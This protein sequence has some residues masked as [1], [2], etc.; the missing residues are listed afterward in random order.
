MKTTLTIAF[1]VIFHSVALAGAK[2]TFVRIE[3]LAEQEISEKILAHIYQKIG[4]DIN[5]IQLPGKR[6]HISVFSENT[7]GETARIFSYGEKN[8]TLIRVP[9]SYNSLETT[10]FAL[11]G[12]KISVTKKEDLNKYR[13]VV[14]RGVQ[15]TKDITKGLQGVVELD[16]ICAMMQFIKLGRADIALTNT[17]SGIGALKRLKTDDIVAVGT[18][19]ELNLYHYLIPKHGDIVPKVDAAIRDM[20]ASG[21]LRELRERFE[22]QY[23][24]NIQ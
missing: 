5:I 21:E 24:D 12:K 23:L 9:T 10:A 22:R 6:A 17:L 1:L 19:E 16:D 13:I 18:L 7:D 4:F 2:Y 8:P 3:S 15:H 14:V 11:K 20:I